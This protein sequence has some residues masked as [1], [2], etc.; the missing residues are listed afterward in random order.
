MLMFYVLAPTQKGHATK[1]KFASSVDSIEIDIHF[2]CSEYYNLPVKDSFDSLS[3]NV[4]DSNNS[5]F[6]FTPL[7]YEKRQLCT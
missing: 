4:I 2:H 7:E 5:K 3:R 1:M 6:F